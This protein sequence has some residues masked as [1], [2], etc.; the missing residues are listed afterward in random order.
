[1]GMVGSAIVRLLKLKGYNHIITKSRAE[2]N[3]LDQSKV[4][5]FFEKYRPE[6]IFICAA[7][8]GGIHAN[9]TLRAQ[10]IYENLQI[11]NNLIH[12]AHTSGV[13]KL[14][15]LGSSCIYPRD[16]PQPIKEEH[17]MTGL[18]EQ[19]N[20]PYAVAK[21]A[22]IKMCENYYRQYGAQFFSIMPTNTYGPN[23]NYDLYTSH[24]FAALIRKFHDAKLNNSD[25]VMLWGTGEPLREFIHVD[26]LADA[27]LYAIGLNFNDLYRKGLTHLN[28]GSGVEISIYELAKMIRE[29]LNVNVNILFD[30]SKPDGTPRKIMSSEKIKDLGWECSIELVEGIKSTYDEYLKRIDN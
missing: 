15:F 18:L 12:F 1:M 2:L 13:K 17:L 9:S 16:C 30:N 28:V 4:R 23:D 21:I 6:Y 3:L 14:L 27:A 25:A 26:D 22:G 29:A 11:Q 19:T 5:L 8:V 7:K 24:V 10:F 20:E